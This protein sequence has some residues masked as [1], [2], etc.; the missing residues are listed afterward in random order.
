MEKSGWCREKLTLAAEEFF[1]LPPT[2]HILLSSCN[3]IARE[4]LERWVGI[5]IPM[6]VETC[7]KHTAVCNLPA[8][9]CVVSTPTNLGSERGIQPKSVILVIIINLRRSKQSLPSHFRQRQSSSIL[10]LSASLSPGSL[11]D[12]ARPSPPFFDPANDHFTILQF[13][14]HPSTRFQHHSNDVAAPFLLGSESASRPFPL[15]NPCLSNQVRPPRSNTP[16]HKMHLELRA[17]RFA[18]G[19]HS[20]YHC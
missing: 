10:V 6:L 20:L 12:L 3:S 15:H 14:T 8:R 19:H 9:P 18:R 11:R 1:D 5:F 13:C 16:T 2:V 7:T 17:F 4:E